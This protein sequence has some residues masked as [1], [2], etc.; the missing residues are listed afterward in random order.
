MDMCLIVKWSVIQIT[1]R[2]VDKKSFIQARYCMTDELNNGLFQLFIYKSE[3]QTFT[4]H[5][6]S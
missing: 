6:N 1:T 2:V 4:G 5:L 3:L